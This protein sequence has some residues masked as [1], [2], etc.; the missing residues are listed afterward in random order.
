MTTVCTGW[1][2]T[3]AEPIVLK[4][5][6]TNDGRVSHGMCSECEAAFAEDLN[7]VH[8]SESPLEYADSS[9]RRYLR[10]IWD[11]RD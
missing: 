2:R 3:H 6:K 7:D 5:D 1:N 8:H 9:Y 4:D 10:D 11:P